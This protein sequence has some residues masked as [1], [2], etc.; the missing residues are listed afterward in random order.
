MS[1][2]FFE[3]HGY[4]IVDLYDASVVY[5]VRA[6]LL[7]RL[8]EITGRPDVTL[9]TYH[10]VVHGDE[11]HTAIQDTLT[12][13]IREESNLQQLVADN[14]RVFSELVGSDMNVQTGPYLRIVRPG[15]AKDNIGFHRD[16]FYGGSVHEISLVIPFVPLD[17]GNA[18]KVQGGSHL[19]PE[20]EIPLLQTK[21]ED[22]TKGS[23]KHG[24]G[25]LYAPKVIDPSYK[26][27]MQP[28]PLSLGQVLA[29]SLATLHGT[30][31]NTSN[32]TRWSVD[33]RIVNR[34]AP[35]DLSARPTYYR[36][37]FGSAVTKIA[38]AYE[39]INTSQPAVKL[40][41]VMLPSPQDGAVVSQEGEKWFGFKKLLGNEAVTF[42]PYF[43]YQLKHSPRHIL[44]SLSYH[45]FAAKMIGQGKT[46]LDV[47]SSE[48]LGT[49]LLADGA[50]RVLGIDIDG[51]AIEVAGRNF[52]GGAVEF[53][54]ADIL[55]DSL[56]EMFDGVVSFDVIEH[57]YPE[58]AALY[59]KKIAQA[60]HDDGVAIIGTPNI[61][62]DRYASETTRA[63]HVNLYDAER[64][65]REMAEYFRH[66]FLFSVNDEMVHTGFTPMAHYLLAM[67]A[68]PKR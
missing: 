14:V 68:G 35:V 5:R 20:R 38:D 37:L 48:G 53:K 54:R 56:G 21:S 3:Q 24:M 44:F 26:L 45:K 50:K 64:L 57:I 42:G 13:Y 60:L 16:T 17:A 61:A 51:P 18:L 41:D 40:P 55:T 4:S 36:P 12:R 46:I 32:N 34:Y 49:M 62:G 15:K 33:M 8:R 31:G 27:S 66:V 47:G 58:R 29:F 2:S 30:E 65:K 9:E 25:F 22:V 1:T 63:G 23:K 19:V 52:G 39:A 6:E 10:T 67:G 28:V 59:I 11:Q 43:S 7:K